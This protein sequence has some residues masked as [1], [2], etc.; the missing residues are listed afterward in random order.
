VVIALVG[1]PFRNKEPTT[2]ERLGPADTVM[3]F[4][5][6]IQVMQLWTRLWRG[7]F[8]S[9]LNGTPHRTRQDSIVNR[10]RDGQQARAKHRP[11]LTFT[12][13]DP[14]S[15]KP[16]T[17]CY[18]ASFSHIGLND[19]ACHHCCH[20]PRRRHLHVMTGIPAKTPTFRNIPGT[21][22]SR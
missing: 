1:C 19:Y 14:A 15:G 2:L 11:K 7:F 10:V 3:I 9:N 12:V 18:R 5:T 4:R 16:T 22:T 13:T 6:N 21:E 17:V 20:W 8:R